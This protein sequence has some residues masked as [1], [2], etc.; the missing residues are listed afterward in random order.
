M[1]MNLCKILI[2]L[3][4][5]LP[6]Q[7]TVHVKIHTL[8]SSR[9]GS[10]LAQRKWGGDVAI[11]SPFF[12]LS[13]FLF[14]RPQLQRVFFSDHIQTQS[15]PHTYEGVGRNTTS[16]TDIFYCV[17]EPAENSA[18]EYLGGEPRVRCGLGLREIEE[19]GR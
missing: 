17:T 4:Y 13:S 6:F 15:P 2:L 9:Y 16:T 8:I 12:Y 14:L 18:Q 11:T 3:N 19:E 5:L 7:W 10:P 1:T